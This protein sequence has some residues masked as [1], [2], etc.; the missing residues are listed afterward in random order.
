MFDEDEPV[1][2][3]RRLIPLVLDTLGVDE[4]RDYIA[5]LRAE[6]ERVEGDIAKKQGHRSQAESFFMADAGI[7]SICFSM[8][9]PYFWVK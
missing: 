6:I 1:K 8:R 5:E 9:R 3:K 2:P 7:D 4:L